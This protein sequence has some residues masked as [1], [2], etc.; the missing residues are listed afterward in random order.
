MIGVSFV[1]AWLTHRFVEQRVAAL[2]VRRALR[3]GGV[4]ALTVL[5]AAGSW[6]GLAA[7]RASTPVLAG[8]PSHP[9]AGRC[10]RSSTSPRSTRPTPS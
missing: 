8:S 2:D 3:T 5:G 1:L 9:G 10:P 4:L 7:A 6:Y